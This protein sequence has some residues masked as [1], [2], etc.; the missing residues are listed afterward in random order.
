MSKSK[1]VSPI[2]VIGMHRS[3]TTMVVRALEK[4]GVFMGSDQ[5]HNSESKFFIK[6]NEW[7]MRQA[8][9]SWDRPLPLEFVRKDECVRGLINKYLKFYL[10]SPRKLPYQGLKIVGRNNTA[11]GWKDPRNTFTVQFWLDIYPDAKILIVERNGLDV[12]TSLVKRRAEYLATA[13]ERFKWIKYFHLFRFNR[14]PFGSSSLLQTINDGI[15]LW[16]LYLLEGRKVSNSY[17]TQSYLVKYEDLLANP[18][19]EIKKIK[20]F[21]E[22]DTFD[23]ET[24]TLK[25]IIQDFDPTRANS[26]KVKESDLSKESLDKLSRY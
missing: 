26:S 17:P 14:Y 8:S 16:Y 9:S 21:L 7:V 24:T 5:E 22:L 4:L 10:K 20:S 6:L 1:R 18:E 25:N 2:I 23:A 11:W 19:I 15:D 13:T 3:G 12:S